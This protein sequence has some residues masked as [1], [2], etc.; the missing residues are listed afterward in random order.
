MLVLAVVA[1]I[2]LATWPFRVALPRPVGN[3]VRVG[4]D[5]SVDFDDPGRMVTTDLEHLVAAAMDSQQLRVA[6]S[7]RPAASRQTGPARIL[8][9][10]QSI[11]RRNLT[12]AQE[13]SDLVVRVRRPGSD[14]NGRPDYVVPQVL[15]AGEVHRVEVRITEAKLVVAVDSTT[16]RWPL[17]PRALAGW[18]PGF[19]LALG[20]EVTGTRP[21]VGRITDVRMQTAT[22]DVDVLRDLRFERPAVWWYVP[23]HLREWAAHP[24]SGVSSYDAAVGMVHLV[25]FVPVGFLLR[26]SWADRP[27][28]RSMVVLAVLIELAKLA[29]VGR[30]A[31]VLNLL[32][33]L[34]GGGIGLVL[35]GDRSPAGARQPVGGGAAR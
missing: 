1:H 3:G 13:G 19:A 34:A 8:T 5:G 6:L 4:A 23:D 12:I 10:S 28:A 9:L 11:H 21:W 29:V 31:S 33:R 25:G 7:V 16:R 22:V 18:T 32:L 20:N 14:A 2:A 24:I 30:H 15:T 35:G 17:P 26:R 27:A